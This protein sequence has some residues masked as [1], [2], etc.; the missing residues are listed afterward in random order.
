MDC[1]KWSNE[2]QDTIGT[3]AIEENQ[4]TVFGLGVGS[5]VGGEKSVY[6]KKVPSGFLFPFSINGYPSAGP[7]KKQDRRTG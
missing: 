7:D 2:I 4:L 1:I 5:I 6:E 3:S